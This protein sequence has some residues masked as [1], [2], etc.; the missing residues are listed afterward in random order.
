MASSYSSPEAYVR[1]YISGDRLGIVTT[2]ETSDVNDMESINESV[3]DAVL[4]EYS[5]QPTE[6]KEL[7]DIPDCD[8]GMHKAIVNYVIWQF[9]EEKPGDENL[10]QASKWKKRYQE[11]LKLNAGRDKIGGI[12]VI[13]PYS[14]R[15]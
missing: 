14:L 2:D 4:I 3:K 15:W 11:E 7:S 12:R 5:A 9:F 8:D 13:K 10:R 1:Y 6:V